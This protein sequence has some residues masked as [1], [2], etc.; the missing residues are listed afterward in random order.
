MAELKREGLKVRD[1]TDVAKETIGLIKEN[2]LAW[3][4][5][6]ISLWEENLK[7]LGNQSDKWFVLEGGCI[8]LLRDLSE[9]FPRER[10]KR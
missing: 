4:K 10:M 5:L 3:L 9:K 8:N 1:I 6:A 2:Y 7:V